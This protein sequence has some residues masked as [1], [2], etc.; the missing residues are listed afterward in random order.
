M[1]LIGIAGRART[2]KDTLA[3]HLVAAYGF[4]R[5]AFADPLKA[6][7]SHIPGWDER[8]LNG[9]LKDV[10]DPFYGVSP[11]RAM[12]TLG[13]EWGR[14]LAPDWWVMV[15]DRSIPEGQ[16]TVISDVRF[17]DEAQYVRERGLLIHL[18]R[19]D[20]P[21]VAGHVSEAGVEVSVDDIVIGNDMGV[22]ALL[23]KFDRLWSELARWRCF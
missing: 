13:T 1:N 14:S 6:M 9:D 4:T 15:A 21:G 22:P 8:Y 23:A 20:A 2:G 18:V 11:R 17:D 10:V 16:K 19:P 3:A 7:L 5:Y 12:Q